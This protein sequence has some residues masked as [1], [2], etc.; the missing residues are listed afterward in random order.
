M[1]AFTGQAG[2]IMGGMSDHVL[3][4]GN[5]VSKGT[6]CEN[7]P[8]AGGMKC[9]RWRGRVVK[10]R[11]AEEGDNARYTQGFGHDLILMQTFR[12]CYQRGKTQP[13]RSWA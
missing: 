6:E 7:S 5:T 4:Q 3:G 13:K 1:S 10:A 11:T 9:N 8:E 12:M 2:S